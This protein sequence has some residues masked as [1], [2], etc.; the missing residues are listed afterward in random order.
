MYI[1]C[2]DGL[3]F[4]YQCD[5]IMRLLTSSVDLSKDKLMVE[6][7]VAPLVKKQTTEAVPLN[8]MPS[9]D[10]F[11][12]PCFIDAVRWTALFYHPSA[13]MFLT[14]GSEIIEKANY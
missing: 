5:H 4:K 1:T 2:I 7:T 3:V 6:W 12:S 10:I 13:M 14:I 8:D 11:S 9:S